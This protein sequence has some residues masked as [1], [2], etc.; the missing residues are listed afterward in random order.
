MEE[1]RG[2]FLHG[3][4][5]PRM[6][7]PDVEAADASGE[8]DEGV[9]VDV[10]ERRALAALDHDGQKIESGSAITR[11]FRSRI[12]LERGPGIAV[13]SSIV[14]VVAIGLTIAESAATLHTCIGVLQVLA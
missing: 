9:P 1:L 8:V 13:L 6:R 5:D 3:V 11:S 10:R 12:S 7:V 14:L 4:D 2:L